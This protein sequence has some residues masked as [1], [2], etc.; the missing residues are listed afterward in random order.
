MT[1]CYSWLFLKHMLCPSILIVID[2]QKVKN[3]NGNYNVNPSSYLKTKK[4]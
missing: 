1:L 4:N 3:Q 2:K